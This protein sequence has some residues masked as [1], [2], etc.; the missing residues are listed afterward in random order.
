MLRGCFLAS[1][2][3][4]KERQ[5]SNDPNLEVFNQVVMAQFSN[6]LDFLE[7]GMK[8]ETDF[9]KHSKWNNFVG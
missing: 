9:S 5:I 1:A 7:V 4:E 6:L 8:D 3:E 2:A